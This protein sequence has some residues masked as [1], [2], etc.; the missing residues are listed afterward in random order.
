MIDPMRRRPT[1][2]AAAILAAGVLGAVADAA[3]APAPTLRLK[4]TIANRGDTVS[5]TGRHWGNHRK[6][7]L[8]VR[9]ASSPARALISTVETTNDGRFAGTVPVRRKATPG[10]YVVLAC[11]KGCAIKVAKPLKVLP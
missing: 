6:V 11:R 10:D 1:R 7:S 2:V 3:T 8:Y 4:P 9:R 5:I